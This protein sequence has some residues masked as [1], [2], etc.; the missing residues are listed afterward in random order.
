MRV[1]WKVLYPAMKEASLVRDCFPEPP[2]PTS[3]ALPRGV[4]MMRDTF[5]R[6]IMASL[7]KTR[8]MP[9]PRMPSLYCWRNICNLS[10]STSKLGICKRPIKCTR[11]CNSLYD[12]WVLVLRPKQNIF[13]FCRKT[14]IIQHLWIQID[15]L[16]M[17]LWLGFLLH[18]LIQHPVYPNTKFLPQCISDYRYKDFTVINIHTQFLLITCKN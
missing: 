3:R 7:K 6:C 11:P 17:K 9:D 15:H 13:W 18:F 12:Y 1:I 16:F 10:S 14:C 2:T 5:T 4:R 8:S